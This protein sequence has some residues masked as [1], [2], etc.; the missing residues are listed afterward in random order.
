MSFFGRS[1]SGIRK[2]I[3]LEPVHIAHVENSA[4]LLFLL[5][6]C[7]AVEYLLQPSSRGDLNLIIH[8]CSNK[9]FCIQYCSVPCMLTI[10]LL[11]P[12]FCQYVNS[13]KWKQ[14]ILTD[15]Q[16]GVRKKKK[17]E[18]QAFKDQG[19][20][21][22]RVRRC[23]RYQVSLCAPEQKKSRAAHVDMS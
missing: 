21:R 6:D 18:K 15:K 1:G 4:F 17:C 3:L 9:T 2:S 16:W 5:G 8:V 19:Q 11:L 7:V 10:T 23:S 22:R 13:C 14:F 12:Y 20:R